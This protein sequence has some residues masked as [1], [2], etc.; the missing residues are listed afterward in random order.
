MTFGYDPYSFFDMP[1]EGGER[2]LVSLHV[3]NL[4][5]IDECEVSFQDGLN[6]LTGETGAG[7]SVLM[8]S[9]NLALGAKADNDLIR[10]GAD[11]ALIELVFSVD[12]GVK[13]HLAKEDIEVDAGDDLVIIRRILQPQRSTL[14]VNGQA[15]TQRQL[16][17]LS[18]L[19]LDMHGQHEH[20]SLL[21]TG[22]QLECLDSYAGSAFSAELDAYREIYA[23]YKSIQKRL[24]EDFAADVNVQKELAI[25]E[26]EYKEIKEAALSVGEEEDLELTCRKMDHLAKISERIS[27]AESLLSDDAP[28]G[29]QGQIQRALRSLLSVSNLD[30]EIEGLTDTLSQAGDIMNDFLHDLRVYADAA[31]FDEETYSN[32]QKRLDLIRH[33]E[34]KFGRTIQDVL[35]YGEEC[36]RK[37]EHLKSFEEE[38]QALNDALLK[39]KERLAGAAFRLHEMRQK[40]ALELKH[41]IEPLLLDMNFLKAEFSVAFIEKEEYTSCGNEEICFMISTNP[42]EELKPLASVAS[43]GEMSRI[44][45]AFKSLM[46]EKDEIDTLIFDEIDTGISGKTAWKVARR[47]AELSKLHQVIA[48]THLPQI[49][50]MADIH[51]C[52]SKSAETG[53]AITGIREL[54]GEGR[55]AEMA[56]LLGTDEVSEAGRENAVTLLSE[57]RSFKEGLS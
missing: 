21:Y 2:M 1:E 47:M 38:K 17:E 22:K 19:L 37:I 15:V 34:D 13:A 53:V 45:L 27:E 51:F 3:K 49:A 28:D 40:A 18:P 29:A 5:L 6:I 4:A 31:V 33:L 16:R 26:Y 9:I 25:T 56:R 12:E 54:D 20:Q 11:S 43:G 30:P 55:I 35:A 44:M 23:E 7:K 52:I 41:N 46:A 39:T 42:G 57:A 36:E 8:D 50:S 32:S 24:T 48:I 14:K 10:R